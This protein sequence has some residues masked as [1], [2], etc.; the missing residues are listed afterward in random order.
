[1]WE[2]GP[3]KRERWRYLLRP[4][5]LAKRLVRGL[6]RSGSDAYCRHTT[7]PVRPVERR[8]W[9]AEALARTAHEHGIETATAEGNRQ[10]YL[11]IDPAS[12]SHVQTLVHVFVTKHPELGIRIAVNPRRGCAGFDKPKRW[13]VRDVDAIA[14]VLLGE[15]WRAGHLRMAEEGCVELLPL[16]WHKG[17]ILARERRAEVV[18]WT[19]R[20][21]PDTPG[22]EP[23]DS[24][25]VP[26]AEYREVPE[27]MDVVYTWVDATDPDWQ[28]AYLDYADKESIEFAEAADSRRYLDREE[29][30]YS[31]RALWL[32]APF[33][34]NIFIVT[35]GHLPDWL[36]TDHPRIQHVTHADVFP[37]AACLP[38]F[39]SHAIEACLHRVPGLSERFLYLNDDVFLGREVA[40]GDFFTQAGLMKS[41]F[42]QSSYAWRVPP[43]EG[44]WPTD[45]V[46]Y[47]ANR[48]IEAQFGMQFQRKHQHVPMAL[49]KEV[50]EEIE[51]WYPEAI[52]GTRAARFRARTDLSVPSMLAHYHAVASGRAVEWPDD[53]LGY[54]YIG[55]DW[56][57]LGDRLERLAARQ[58]AFFCLNTTRPGSLDLDEQE[59]LLRAFLS[60][61][62]PCASPYEKDRGD[63]D[64]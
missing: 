36:D 50:L 13:R 22:G 32:Y 38:T 49:R 5:A 26:R 47:N 28:A 20:F 17:R 11:A 21:S 44:A 24:G 6:W 61:R 55:T 2:S 34:R 33:V 8:R 54:T 7:L 19:D 45:W 46:S 25:G 30:R 41:R 1:M 62:Y 12:A 14:S 18:D 37:D 60:A 35:A 9:L 10:T 52:E 58:P 40:P 3:L 42:A 29:L 4:R 15:P 48:L 31:L 64:T 56:A 23:R 53:G 27:S 57:D 59:R 16:D 51:A 39:N 43:G 63:I